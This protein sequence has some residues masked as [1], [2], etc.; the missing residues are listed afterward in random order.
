MN[1]VSE[2]TSSPSGTLNQK[3]SSQSQE[4][5]LEPANTPERFVSKNNFANFMDQ[6]EEIEELEEPIRFAHDTKEK[7]KS[8][9]TRR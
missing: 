1:I 7:I 8:I 3:N 9:E 2:E 5:S 4:K 6:I